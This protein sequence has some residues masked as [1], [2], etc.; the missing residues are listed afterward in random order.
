MHLCFRKGKQA[1]ST[2]KT[3]EQSLLE[4]ERV[5]KA[6]V[7][8][9]EAVIGG[10]KEV[11]QKV[12]DDKRVSAKTMLVNRVSSLHLDLLQRSD[13]EDLVVSLAAVSGLGM[14]LEQLVNE[15]LV[16]YKHDTH[17][18]KKKCTE[19]SRTAAAESA[20]KTAEAA[21]PG[22]I[23]H[24]EQSDAEECADRAEQDKRIGRAKAAWIDDASDMDPTLLQTSR[25]DDA[26]VLESFN[27]D[28]D[29]HLEHDPY[30]DPYAEGD[31]YAFPYDEVVDDYADSDEDP[32]SLHHETDET[33]SATSRETTESSDTASHGSEVLASEN[34]VLSRFKKQGKI[35]VTADGQYECKLTM[36]SRSLEDDVKALNEEVKRIRTKAREVEKQLE[37]VRKDKETDYGP[38]AVLYTLKNKCFGRAVGKYKYEVCLFDRVKQDNMKLGVFSKLE[39]IE[40][41]GSDG[42]VEKEMVMQFTKGTKCWNG[43]YRALTLKLACGKEEQLGEVTEPSMCQ[44]EAVFTTPAA[45]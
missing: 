28:D 38:E 25:L 31:A 2:L 20:K 12:A 1:I 45:C 17:L 39:T 13:L 33:D 41:Q 29:I 10:F 16:K 42:T 26:D 43:P 23:E 7:K 37:E 4:K 30:S 6:E 14:K 36:P 9:L 32:A 44:Y 21:S 11:Q 15:L 19:K 34:E 24:A 40:K 22:S 3:R 35:L 18:L 8:S 27:D 5:L